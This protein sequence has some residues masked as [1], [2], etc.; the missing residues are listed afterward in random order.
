MWATTRGTVSGEDVKNRVPCG[1]PVDY[2]R[3]YASASAQTISRP[4]R[5]GY[6]G[7]RADQ[8]A[9]PDGVAGRYHTGNRQFRSLR[10]TLVADG[11]G[12]HWL[13]RIG[14][15]LVATRLN[16]CQGERARGGFDGSE[17]SRPDQTQPRPE[18][19]PFVRLRPSGRPA[20]GP[21]SRCGW[22]SA[23]RAR[24]SSVASSRCGS[25]HRGS[26]ARRWCRARTSRHR[27]LP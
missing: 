6:D 8:W 27:C 1:E 18:P 2:P 7:C 17:T 10:T 4:Y 19:A 21:S 13:H 25:A 26:P 15:A 24:R 22:S 20:C 3:L 16:D 5:M 9:G 14:T 11:E 23:R 12:I